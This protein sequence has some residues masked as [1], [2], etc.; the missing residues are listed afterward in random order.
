MEIHRC[1]ILGFEVANLEYFKDFPCHF[2][3]ALPPW[4][5]HALQTDP[6]LYN[7]DYQTHEKH[8]ETAIRTGNICF[9]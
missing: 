7:D 8:Q 4:N 1:W 2:N 3:A 9:N 5:H 6:V